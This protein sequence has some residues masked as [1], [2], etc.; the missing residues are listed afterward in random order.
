[1]IEDVVMRRLLLVVF[2]VTALAGL[3]SAC[4]GDGTITFVTCTD[5]GTE[6]S[7]GGEGCTPGAT[8]CEG[9]TTQICDA[10]G[11][12]QSS[13]T[14]PYVCDNGACAGMC[15]PST[16]QCNGNTPQSCDDTGTWQS[17]APCPNVCSAGKCAGMCASGSTQCSDKI[18]QTCDATGKW[19]DGAACPF[20]CQGGACTGVCSPNATQCLG[21]TPQTCNAT[22]QWQSG[23]ACP[24]LCNQGAC[25]GMCT[26]GSQQSCGGAATCNAGGMKTCDATGTWGAC[27][28]AASGCTTTPSGWSPVAL[29]SGACPAGFGFPQVYVS[30]VSASPYT[31]S[32][33]C[34]GTQVCTGTATLN[35][36]TGATCTGSPV[37][38]N[39]ISLSTTCALTPGQLS[40]AAGDGYLLSN[41]SLTP[42]PKCSATPLAT[43]MPTPS[44]SKIT[45]CQPNLACPGGACLT[46]AE[47]VAM[48]VSHAG[49]V[50][51]P[52]GFPT[53]TIVSLGVSDTRTCG[54]CACGSS[55][56]CN[57]TSLLIDNDPG[58]STANPYN[59]TEGA[60]V[61]VASPQSF[62]LNA[63]KTNAI[64]TGSGTCAQTV[65]S[66]PAGGVALDPAWTT[67]VCCP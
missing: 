10:T 2:V 36:Y 38:S 14:C 7:D 8:R 5:G 47:Q 45:V 20:V 31:C 29:T 18:P 58:C 26:P 6:C 39:V 25:A 48:C 66:V 33:S 13:T 40:T 56:G 61:C 37:A 44:E 34:G 9:T 16:T 51:C 50:A 28:P 30:A 41:V 52:A 60:G 24:F 55:L 12:W 4:G 35:H 46:A 11:Q 22:G 43:N 57:F 59:F 1:M 17:E 54:A 67:T 32:C 15:V 62:P 42:G 3:A 49:S 19:V 53:Q 64:I 21:N 27:V 65:P 63:T 23:T